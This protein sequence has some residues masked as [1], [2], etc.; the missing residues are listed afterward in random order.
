MPPMVP[1]M[2]VDRVWPTPTAVLRMLRSLKALEGHL[3]RWLCFTPP[4]AHPNEGA[5]LV[6]WHR[7]APR[8]L[9]L[10]IVEK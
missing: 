2:L 5:L 3:G 4:E 7:L 9:K 8:M 1:V 6:V 10:T